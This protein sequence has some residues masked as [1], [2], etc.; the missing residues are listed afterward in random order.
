MQEVGNFGSVKLAQVHGQGGSWQDMDNTWGAAWEIVHQPQ[1]P[2]DLRIVDNSGAEVPPS[3]SYKHKQDS[4]VV[5]DSR[6]EA[7]PSPLSS[8][9]SASSP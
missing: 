6:A 3:L 4:C 9:C 8:T 7:C 2:L 1:P 5:D